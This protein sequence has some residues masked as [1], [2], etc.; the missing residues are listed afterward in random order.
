MSVEPLV[1]TAIVEEGNPK[2]VYRSGVGK[3]EFQI[4]SEEFEWIENRFERR[5]PIT[6]RAFR[7]RFPDFEYVIPKE[8]LDDLLEELKTERAYGQIAA[9]IET[10]SETL[11]PDNVIE[12][13]EHMREVLADVLKTYSPHSEISMKDSSDHLQKIR[14]HR[15]LA[16]AGQTIGMPLLI[17]SLDYHFDGAQPGRLIAIL[18]RPGEGKSFVVSWISWISIKTGYI[19]GLFSPEM[20]E[21][22]H[23]CR[24]HTLASADPEVQK[25]CGLK[26]SFRNRDLMRGT[27]FNLKQYKTFLEYFETLPGQCHIFTKKYRKNALTLQYLTSKVEDLGL[28]GIIADPLSK[29]ST[30]VRR[31]DNPVWEAYD[32]VAGLQELAEEHNI[33]AVATNWATRQQGRAKSEKAPDLDD[34]FGSDALAQESDHVIGVKHDAEERTLT[35]RCTK[36]RFGKPRFNAIIDFH[37]NTGLFQ[38]VNIDHDVMAYRISLNGKAAPNGNGHKPKHAKKVVSKAIKKSKPVKAKKV[39]TNV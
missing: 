29:L 23:L 24:V 33:F 5:K 10:V 19:T 12:E 25:A 31:R 3:N 34:S 28:H 15:I 4:Y 18:G 14:Q 1:V 21:F 6:R 39:K 36:S 37:P 11:L 20:N 9:L 2:L 35:L 8:R 32:K 7:E 17:P 16:K 22:E 38:E 30:G 27:G 26:R 13:A